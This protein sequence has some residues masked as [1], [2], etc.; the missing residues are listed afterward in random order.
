VAP[1]GVG[2]G[3]NLEQTTKPPAVIP[4]AAFCSAHAQ[5]EQG[6]AAWDKLAGTGRVVP[7]HATAAVFRPGDPDAGRGWTTACGTWWASGECGR[8]AR[9]TGLAAGRPSWTSIGGLRRSTG[10]NGSGR[11][12]A[13]LEQLHA[14]PQQLD[15]VNWQPL[16]LADGV[17]HRAYG[18]SRVPMHDRPWRYRCLRTVRPRPAPDDKTNSPKKRTRSNPKVGVVPKNKPGLGASPGCHRGARGGQGQLPLHHGAAPVSLSPSLRRS[19]S[20][21]KHVCG[22]TTTKTTPLTSPLPV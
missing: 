13:E 15:S 21:D 14:P 6:P 1:S 22:K 18:P 10:G 17:V 20:S 4:T 9:A 7:A 12:L 11:A 19:A 8:G 5:A 16:A 2:A 3:A